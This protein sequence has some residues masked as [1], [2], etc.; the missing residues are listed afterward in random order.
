M[1]PKT[2]TPAVPASP[3][4]PLTA[5]DI[6]AKRSSEQNQR[7]QTALER[8][9]KRREADA[10]KREALIKKM[11]ADVLKE[12]QLQDARTKSEIA[13]SNNVREL[14]TKHRIE[15]EKKVKKC[16][17][18]AEEKRKLVSNH[19]LT[20]LLKAQAGQTGPAVPKDFITPFPNSVSKP[21]DA[22]AA[23]EKAKMK[24]DDK[25]TMLDRIQKHFLNIAEEMQARKQKQTDALHAAKSNYFQTPQPAYCDPTKN[26]IMLKT[27]QDAAQK[28]RKEQEQKEAQR[29][30]QYQDKQQAEELKK[31]KDIAS[32][33]QEQQ[34]RMLDDLERKWRQ[35]AADHISKTQ[36]I[37]AER[38]RKAELLN[39]NKNPLLYP[40]ASTLRSKSGP[41]INPHLL[42]VP[43]TTMAP[44]PEDVKRR[45][46]SA[47]KIKLATETA[48]K[49][50][51]ELQ[52]K[53]KQRIE[54]AQQLLLNSMNPLAPGTN[55]MQS[56]PRRTDTVVI[57]QAPCNNGYNIEDGRL[58]AEAKR[59]E[60]LAIEFANKK[61]M[62]ASKHDDKVAEM[63]RQTYML[64]QLNEA[65]AKAQAAKKDV[66]TEV[67]EKLQASIDRAYMLASSR[68]L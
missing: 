4:R 17:E 33:N 27:A 64:K 9:S 47:N 57:N 20:M 58:L 7:L 24:K 54:K 67:A 23:A 61:R 32:N 63:M 62:E 49:K 41:T 56:P 53:E 37:V 5:A 45:A 44:T 1:P 31:M 19:A 6:D 38:H 11:E 26:A 10:V 36:D 12:K 60:Q 51:N 52:A 55:G 21:L 65:K 59:R 15:A 68:I 30:K 35:T 43:M 2:A 14:D 8:V 46:E 66:N 3:P 25:I 39:A 50:R 42:S 29:M 13:L 16:Q 34:K 28:K 40:N 22:K 18:L 48:M